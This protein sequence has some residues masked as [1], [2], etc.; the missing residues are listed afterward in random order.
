VLHGYGQLAGAFLES[1]RALASPQRVLV[2]PE[3]LS[4]FY[5]RRGTGEVGAS[6]MTREARELE[7]ADIVRYLDLVAERVLGPRAAEVSIHALGFSQGAAAAARWAAMGRW[8]VE[9]LTL[10][11]GG[12]P[13]DLDLA[14]RGQRLR[15]TS[16]TLVRGE[17]DESVDREAL[18]R[19]QE[20]LRA[21][22]IAA[23]VLTFAGG[24]ELD[25]PTLA[26]LAR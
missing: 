8:S 10:W 20:R 24:H 21:A 18:E 15:G 26:H 16:V 17:R 3:A 1:F 22:G 23:E 7:I 4:R 19:D 12:F 9:R 5:L 6:W 14:A 13:P 11:G 25:E 2:A